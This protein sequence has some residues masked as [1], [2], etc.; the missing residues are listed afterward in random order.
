MKKY[1]K[2]SPF[3]AAAAGVL[4]ALLRSWLLH[5]GTDERGL[6]PSGHPGWIGYAVLSVAMVAAF[7]LLTREAEQEPAWLRNFSNDFPRPA[8]TGA[9][10]A[11]AAVG[12]GLHTRTLLPGPNIIN[13]FTY[14]CGFAC[15]AALLVTGVLIFI[16]KKPFSMIF[17]VPCVYFAALMFLV[18]Q[19]FRGEPELLR[20]LPQVVALACC[21]LAGYQLW[22]FAADCG[23]RSAS[24]F[25]SFCAIYFCL[26]AAP[27]NSVLYPLLG[28]WQLLSHCAPILP[29]EAESDI[30]EDSAEIAPEEPL[31]GEEDA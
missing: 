15:V 2:L 21:A 9:G 30:W 16:G 20:Y 8:I 31:P 24:L 28:L 1:L 14:W 6:Y 25:W 11:L 29:A 4:G 12:I 17:A 23:N 19:Q 22:G 3:C 5:A 7:W 27:G 10:Y 13:L 26:A 18:S